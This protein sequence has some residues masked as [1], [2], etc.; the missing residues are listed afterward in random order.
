MGI[1]ER[2]TG[3]SAALSRLAGAITSLAQQPHTRAESADDSELLGG[4]TIDQVETELGSVVDS[5]AAQRNNPHETT[6]E[7]VGMYTKAELD[8][9]TRELVPE[10]IIPISNY[11]LQNYLPVG[12]SGSFE[13]ASTDPTYAVFAM[14]L[15]QDGTLV[16]LRSGTNG[17][18]LGI[19]YSYIPNAE[20]GPLESPVRTSRG[21]RP[22]YFPAGVRA[23]S[24]LQA[25]EYNIIGS[26]VDSVN[27]ALT[28]YFISLTNGTMD[29]SLH[30]GITLPLSAASWL[31]PVLGYRTTSAVVNNE[32]LFFTFI[33][34]GKDSPL[35]LE[36]HSCST[37]DIRNG[38][39][40]TIGKVTGILTDGIYESV[41]EHRI[42]IASKVLSND[43]ADKSL[44]L[45]TG[46]SPDTFNFCQ[47]N[48]IS[49]YCTDNGSGLVRVAMCIGGRTAHTGYTAVRFDSTVSLVYDPATKHAIVD[50]GIDDQVA[51]TLTGGNIIME[52]GLIEPTPLNLGPPP[53]DAVSSNLILTPNGVWF[54]YR[55]GTSVDS[56]SFRRNRLVTHIDK[57]SSI[58][59]TARVN[60]TAEVSASDRPRFPTALGS[61]LGGPICLSK[62]EI[63]LYASGRGEVDEVKS[64]LVYVQLEGGPR[65]HQYGSSTGFV[66]RVGYPPSSRRR[67]LSDMGVN[68]LYQPISE[69]IGDDV[70]LSNWY[71]VE[72]WAHGSPKAQFL[73]SD[74]NR[75]GQSISCADTV[76][77]AAATLIKAE[78][79]ATPAMTGATFSCLIVPQ[80]SDV[81]AFMWV[82]TR[83]S[84]GGQTAYIL[85]EVDDLIIVDGVVTE[86][87]P[88]RV[89]SPSLLGSGLTNAANID[90][91]KRIGG[92]H[93]YDT[94]TAV[95]IGGTSPFRSGNRYR[96]TRLKWDKVNK[97]FVRDSLRVGQLIP[98]PD[99]DIGYF[100]SPDLGFC[101]VNGNVAGADVNDLFTKCIVAPVATTEAEFDAWVMPPRTEW[102]VLASQDVAEGWNLYFTNATPLFMAGRSYVIE[103][104]SVD[105]RD[106]A[107]DPTNST[108]HVYIQL[109]DGVPEYVVCLEELEETFITMFIG[110]VVTGATQIESIN[111]DKVYRVDNIR[112]STLPTGS[113]IP[114][115]SGHPAD[116]SMLSW[117]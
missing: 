28:G 69:V 105:L 96:P 49:V 40:S 75:T 42:R 51:V 20:V 35:E 74:F 116:E 36:V 43:P 66:G 6:G 72:G 29:D 64:D 65:D 104:G 33:N 95:L 115:S 93:F 45:A 47:A 68:N 73:D 108:F 14:A 85:A 48:R 113:S 17:S 67:F 41:T 53:E 19:Y 83:Q 23:A 52:G 82:M 98:P 70:T 63:I 99:S 110:T 114:S 24:I 61:T 26:L 4:K 97:E 27:G 38:T 25:S 56:T 50:E 59:R 88:G 58:K 10:G 89:Y 55:S 31:D 9:L 79:Y 21:Y 111:I 32:L 102:V 117:S 18:K 107:T 90:T 54:N 62:N 106:M 16:M 86:I 57:F 2:V 101:Q 13:G 92:W 84:S 39:L 11:G 76:L 15:E 112:I 46:I 34:P 1:N 5:H 87:V 30:V 37:T 60:S 8:S 103:P 3:L 109:V 91:L 78:I 94:P 80:V 77:R 7:K 81:P 22:P 100:A 44:F 12:V 71:F